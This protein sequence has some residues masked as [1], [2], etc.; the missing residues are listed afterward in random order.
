M[1]GEVL[2]HVSFEVERNDDTHEY[3]PVSRRM[4]NQK[5]NL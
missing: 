4:K 1:H 5:Y 3:T 2:K